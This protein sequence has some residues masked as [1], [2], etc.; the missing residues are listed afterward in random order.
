MKRRDFIGTALAAAT[1]PVP[2]SASIDA[3][4]SQPERTFI[5]ALADTILPGAGAD[6]TVRLVHGFFDEAPAEKPRFQAGLKTLEK[7]LPARFSALS[8]KKRNT[9]LNNLFKNALP[10]DAAFALDVVRRVALIEFFSR[11]AG[12]DLLGAPFRTAP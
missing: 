8:A 2:V 3:V 5:G 7:G 1:L 10:K 12:R 6:E 4:F 11:R 9:L